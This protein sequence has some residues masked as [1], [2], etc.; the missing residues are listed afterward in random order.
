MKKIILSFC[1]LL[2]WAGVFAQKPIEGDWMGKLNLGPQS[3]TIVLHVNC[4]AQGEVE[5]I[6]DSPDQGAK[7]IA[8]ETDY[9]SSDSISV[10]LASLALSFQGKLKGDE[11]V[12][13]FTQGLS[14]SLILK[15]GEEKLNRPQNPVAPY[16][17]KTE[18]VA[19]KNV[20]DGATLVGTLSYP[21][22]YKKGQTPVV[23][24][25]TG[26]GQE[27]RDEE[28]F[29]HK[30][31]LVIAD[32]LARHGVAT[33]RYDDRG[34]GKSTGGDVEH[35]TTLDFMRD[36]ASGVDFLRTSKQFG[37]VGI[38]GHSEGG[39]I[40][41]MLGAK[42]KVDFVIS[43]AGIGVKGD[44][45][46]TAQANKIFELTGQSMRFST[47]QYRM[48]AIIKRSPWLNFFIDYDPSA[49]ISKTLCPVMAING[50][51]DVQVIS[52]LNLA[53]IKAHLKPNPKNII[54]E[55]PSLNHLFQHCKTGNVLEYRMIE[56]TI[57][58]EV[59]EDIVRFIKQ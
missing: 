54:K 39:S 49:D 33:L 3:L 8:V 29:D 28:I 36:A 44:T 56:E 22:G 2:S 51:R 19:F 34:F 14:F 27:N 42:G 24:M 59:L 1:L 15:R 48:N 40:A 46:L 18:E 32:Y 41:F 20:A 11:I 26:S 38:L 7:G 25:V 16:P 6:L 30:P 37:K 43:M 4:N 10:S 12:G 57:S 23:L 45:A 53:G 52:S 31:F 13:T 58:P 17:Y 9:C 21:I 55:Y 5:C 47:H 35:A 50:S